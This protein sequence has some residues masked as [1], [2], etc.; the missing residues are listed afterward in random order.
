MKLI[1]IL[2][3]FL[4]IISTKSFA[5]SWERSYGGTLI[6]NATAVCQTIDS[7]FIVAGSTTSFGAGAFDF[8]FVKTDQSGDT[9]WTKTYGGIYSD[10]CSSVIQTFDGG[11]IACGESNSFSTYQSTYLVKTDAQ[12]ILSWSKI[13]G[14]STP[15][16]PGNMV[17][18]ADSGYCIVGTAQ[19]VATGYSF[20]FLIRTDINGDTLWTK[21]FGRDILNI[22]Y[23]LQQTPDNGFIISGTSYDIISSAYDLYLIKTNDQGDTLWTKYMS[24]SGN[25]FG[26]SIILGVNEYIIGGISSEN[27]FALSCDL[28]GNVNW[29][30]EYDKGGLDRCYSI[31]SVQGNGFLLGGNS[32]LQGSSDVLVIKIDS[33]GNELWSKKYGGND[34]DAGWSVKS[35]QSGGFVIGGVT[36]NLVNHSEDFYLIRSDCNNFPSVQISVLDTICMGD[37][38][39]STLVANISSGFTYQW[40]KDDTTI[41]GSNTAS[42]V[43][44]DGA[45]YK[46]N[47]IDS[48]GCS[49]ISNKI[50]IDLPA[51]YFYSSPNEA[52]AGDIIKFGQW[53]FGGD[54]YQYY[55]WDL[56][57]G[58][59]DT[60]IN[61]SHVYADTGWYEVT[62]RVIISNG[63]CNSFSDSIH[64]TTTAIPPADFDMLINNSNMLYNQ[65][66]PGDIIEFTPFAY[67]YWFVPPP[68]FDATT[69]HWDF[70]DGNTDTVPYPVHYYSQYGMFAV[71]LTVTNHC[72]NSNSVSDSIRIDSNIIS[73]AHF[74]WKDANGIFN[75][76]VIACE[77]VLFLADGGISYNWDFGD[78]VVI[79]GGDS[80]IHAYTS[81]VSYQVKLTTTNNCG[82]SDTLIHTVVVTGT[83]NGILSPDDYHEAYTFVFPNPFN[84]NAIIRLNDFPVNRI[85]EFNL[86]IYDLRGSMTRCSNV[87]GTEILIYREQLPA[88]P[89]PP[90]PPGSRGELREKGSNIGRF[91]SALA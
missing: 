55:D 57:D 71:T 68:P 83:C 24:G 15:Q 13:I 72:G 31:T 9:L 34:N 39:G 52:C 27:F 56:G 53:S 86:Q 81:A 61:I 62:R 84:E 11:Y 19:E 78:G 23:S 22:G 21:K 45:F 89:N 7:G 85:R 3:W 51:P 41:V 48:N 54:N 73:V 70:G 64:I 43:A 66:C 87:S 46:L 42:Y 67:T 74:T 36:T 33:I 26:Q 90:N 30:H 47:V 32:I 37:T 8:Y 69:Y 2:P 6:E 58:S 18:T 82:Y 49:N 1:I 38:M 25:T 50:Y 80:M 17:Q 12:G 28:N 75:D 14:D 65:A 5:Q 44:Y 91:R 20:V 79:T 60:G 35:L 16:S 59:T 77:Q 63:S 4:L 10:K 76:T 88:G 29:Q 40:L